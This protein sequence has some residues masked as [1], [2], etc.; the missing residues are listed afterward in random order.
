MA[1]YDRGDEETARIGPGDDLVLAP[2][3]GFRQ[4]Q[5]LIRMAACRVI[6]MQGFLRKGGK[7]YAWR[8]GGT[9][10]QLVLLLIIRLRV[11]CQHLSDFSKCTVCTGMYICRT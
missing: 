6:N 4:V 11:E 10:G 8:G 3:S 1:L 7:L 9:A 5:L 2:P